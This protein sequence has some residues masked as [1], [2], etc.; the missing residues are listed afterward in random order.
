MSRTSQWHAKDML[1]NGL[2]SMKA[3]FGKYF[4][5]TL[6]KK[7][8]LLVLKKMGQKYACQRWLSYSAG[9]FDDGFKMSWRCPRLPFDTVSIFESIK[10]I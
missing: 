2:L 7:K 9:H 1:R 8:N 5:G 10:N 4:F 6:K 3:I